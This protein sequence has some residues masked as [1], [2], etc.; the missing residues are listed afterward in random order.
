MKKLIAFRYIEYCGA[1]LIAFGGSVGRIR[2]YAHKLLQSGIELNGIELY[3][4]SRA[5]ESAT[6]A[7]W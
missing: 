6:P 7:E 3:H 4:H 1:F 5:G 2:E